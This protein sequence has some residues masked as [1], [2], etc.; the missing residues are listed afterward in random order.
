MSSNPLL[1]IM[2]NGEA[3]TFHPDAFPGS[4]L[5]LIRL[6]E[7]TPDQVVAE[8]NGELVRRAEAGER[9]IADGDRVE[10]VQFVGGG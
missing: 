3:R 9:R 6:L 4:L 8:I 5:D 1:E 2:V 7:L 10:L